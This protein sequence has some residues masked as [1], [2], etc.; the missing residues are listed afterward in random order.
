MRRSRGFL[1]EALKEIVMRPGQS[2]TEIAKRL[3]SEGRATSVA[4]NPVGSLVATL[5]KYHAERHVL[6]RRWERGQYRYY[7]KSET[8]EA[9]PQP[10][11]PERKSS[12][13]DAL[14]LQLP[15]DCL[16]YV[17]ALAV[18]PQFNTSLDAIVWLLRKG[19]QS[20]RVS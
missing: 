6:E 19:M 18:L 15:K 2:A 12:S 10:P 14:L 13:D 17:N 20:T 8:D 5:H 11:E 7:P 1:E 9:D 3:L 16:E 4:K